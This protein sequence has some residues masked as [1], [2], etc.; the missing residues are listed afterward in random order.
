MAIKKSKYFFEEGFIETLGEV[1]EEK[2]INLYR[3]TI[4]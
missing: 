4:N 3:Q 2:Y 1:T